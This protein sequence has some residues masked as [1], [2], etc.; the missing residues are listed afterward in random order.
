MSAPYI[1]TYN[2]VLVPTKS[3]E[4]AIIGGGCAGLS[5]ARELAERQTS[6]SV[7]ILEPRT[8]YQDD[9]SWCFWAPQQHALSHLVSHTWNA[10][11]FGQHDQ[12]NEKRGSV[13][14]PYQYIRSSDFY[15]DC[16]KHIEQCPAIESR[17]GTSVLKLERQLDGWSIETDR[18]CLYATHV[19]D[20]RP[21]SPQQFA[22]ATL[23]QCFLGVEIELSD[24]IIIDHSTIELMTD[25]RVVN[26]DYCFTYLLPFSK[27]RILIEHTVFSAQPVTAENL[28]KPLNLLL[29]KRGLNTASIIR[30]EHAILPMG[31]P[32]ENTELPRA[33][34]G[35]GA[36][37]P[38]SGYG[39]MRIQGWARDCATQFSEQGILSPHIDSGFILPHMDQLFLKVLR[40]Q[41]QLTP[42][43]FQQLLGQADTERFIRFM[44]DKSNFFDYLNI[45]SSLPKTPF[46]KA[47]FSTYFKST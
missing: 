29:E 37:R 32:I 27:N 46:V 6:Q 23:Y 21:P 25:M 40:L 26:G 19:I 43:L 31:L 38:S 12:P 34:I 15:Q 18:E 5:L 30:T 13:S 39:F 10:W 16:W 20:T 11:L 24:E 33:G 47:L 36:L 4:L 8:H 7:M 44:T 22:Q 1:D 41:P 14:H 9:R 42:T 28:Q 35:G 2:T 3:L 17:L 45:I